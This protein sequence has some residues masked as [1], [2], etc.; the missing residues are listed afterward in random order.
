MYFII[1]AIHLAVIHE[2]PIAGYNLLS[3]LSTMPDK[4]AINDRNDLKQVCI[5]RC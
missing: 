5:D 4:E 2:L 1:S 3:V